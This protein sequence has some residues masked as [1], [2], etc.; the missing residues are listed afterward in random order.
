MCSC[1]L[2]L[3]ADRQLACGTCL[4]PNSDGHGTTSTADAGI[5]VRWICHSSIIGLLCLAIHPDSIPIHDNAQTEH[6]GTQYSNG[7][8]H[9][10]TTHPSTH[11]PMRHTTSTPAPSKRIAWLFAHWDTSVL[12]KD[13]SVSTSTSVQTCR[14]MHACPQMCAHT[15]GALHIRSKGRE[16]TGC[17]SSPLSDPMGLLL[18]RT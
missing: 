4:D 7:G 9:I 1:L 12:S 5:W 16:S 2:A 10:P 15:D 3:A 6:I 17:S 14:H 18:R 11:P 13:T 8:A